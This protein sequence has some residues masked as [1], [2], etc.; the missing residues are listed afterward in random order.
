MD[1]T[2]STSRL[3]QGSTAVVNVP[4]P[5]AN[6]TEDEVDQQLWK[7]DGKIQQKRDEKL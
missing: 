1:A 4:R 2:P 7:L 6:V 5:L 3:S